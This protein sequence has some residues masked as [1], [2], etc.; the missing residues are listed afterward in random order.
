MY[1]N[2]LSIRL[3]KIFYTFLLLV[4]IKKEIESTLLVLQWDRNRELQSGPGLGPART[5]TEILFFTGAGPG[6]NLPS[7]SVNFLS[8]TRLYI[9]LSVIFL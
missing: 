1:E 5:R 3:Y 7:G 9:F 4:S 8:S 2:S 6:L